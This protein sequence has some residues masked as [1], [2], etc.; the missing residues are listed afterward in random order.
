MGAPRGIGGEP[1]QFTASDGPQNKMGHVIL[2][3]VGRSCLLP[4]AFP[5]LHSGDKPKTL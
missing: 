1:D 4:Q 2:T 5:V 3:T